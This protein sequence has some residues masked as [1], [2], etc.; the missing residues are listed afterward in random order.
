MPN[1]FVHIELH[2]GD[3][4]KAKDFYGQLLD[5]K[6]EDMD[7]GEMTYTMVN[8]GDEGT[9]GG[10]MA[11]MSPEAPSAWMPYVSVDDVDAAASKV[12]ELGGTILA[13][14]Q[15]VPNMGWFV[16]IA[17]PTGATIGLWQSVA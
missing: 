7:M 1:P 10:I 4:G 2:T 14:K 9:G 8:V 6:L 11:K 3:T 16:I 5:W 12:S 13:E 15:E 17:D